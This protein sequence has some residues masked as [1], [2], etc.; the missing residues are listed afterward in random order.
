VW[1]PRFASRAFPHAQQRQTQPGSESPSKY[2]CSFAEPV[3]R[4]ERLSQNGL[5]DETD[6]RIAR[7]EEVLRNLRTHIQGISRSILFLP[8]SSHALHVSKSFLQIIV[9]SS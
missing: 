8:F 9:P 5:R 6:A 2:D 4:M 7:T 1:P 3:L